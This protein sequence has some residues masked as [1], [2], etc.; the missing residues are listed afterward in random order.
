MSGALLK[1]NAFVQVTEGMC[2]YYDCPEMGGESYQGDEFFKK[3]RGKTGRVK[4]FSEE[5]VGPLDFKGRLP[6]VYIKPGYIH[7]QFDGEEEVHQSLNL[8]HFILLDAGQTVVPVTVDLEHQKVRDL[9]D[10]I[11]FWPGDQVRKTD[12]LLYTVRFIERVYVK[13]DGT[14][15]Y[16]LAKIAEEVQQWQDETVDLTLV[17]RGNVY[18]LYHDPAQLTFT[19]PKDEVSFW[20]REGVSTTVY[21]S[22]SNHHRH[23]SRWEWSLEEARKMV[24]NGAGDLVI[25]SKQ[26]EHV[27][28]ID[29]DGDFEVRKLHSCFAHHRERVR[30]LS[31]GLAEPPVEV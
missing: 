12:D 10:P 14:V 30:A 7:V 9:P 8:Q 28:I 20:A 11:E 16:V 1:I 4:G 19:S 15:S 17:A 13:G 25:A 22:N 24:E 23:T 27:I 3:N 21:G 29:R 5:F 31:L 26:Y 6:G 2:V 18:H